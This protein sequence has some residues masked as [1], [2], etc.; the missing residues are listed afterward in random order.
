[1]TRTTLRSL[2]PIALARETVQEAIDR[3]HS[4]AQAIHVAITCGI[5]IDVPNE[6]TTLGHAVQCLTR[7]A[8]TGAPLAAPLSEY[9]ITLVGAATEALDESQTK[10]PSSDLARVLAAAQARDDAERGEPVRAVGLACLGDVHPV[11]VRQLV[12]G[13]E[14]RA[15]ER[16]YVRADDA[17]RW[18]ASRGVEVERRK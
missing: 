4:L 8:Q 16:G 1:M 14:L 10:E 17:R 5:D 18:L 3:V 7:Y 12:E 9:L 6:A 2:D 15:A 13:G 11:R